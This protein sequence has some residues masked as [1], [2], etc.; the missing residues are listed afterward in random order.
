MTNQQ[1]KKTRKSGRIAREVKPA[2]FSFKGDNS[3]PDN[4]KD[5]QSSDSLSGNGRDIKIDTF[6]IF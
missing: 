5:P 2:K 3:N 1:P 4:N 6:L